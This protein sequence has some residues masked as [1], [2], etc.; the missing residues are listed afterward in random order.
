M[1][2]QRNG[3]TDATLDLKKAG[4]GVTVCVRG[5]DYGGV[6][7]GIVSGAWTDGELAVYGRI[8]DGP[9]TDTTKRLTAADPKSGAIDL[10]EYTELRVVVLT[11][12]TGSGGV[13]Q[14][15]WVAKAPR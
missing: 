15:W 10:V 14:P 9:W 12:D 1:L 2:D 6:S 13:V 11:A 7:A 4:V 5:G 8:G 3:K